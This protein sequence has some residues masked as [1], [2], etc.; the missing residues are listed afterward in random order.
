MRSFCFEFMMSQKD[1][2]IVLERDVTELRVGKG[3]HNE[4]GGCW[5][6]IYM[7]PS[8]L[9][10]RTHVLASTILPVTLLRAARH[11]C[12]PWTCSRRQRLL[13]PFSRCLVAQW[14]SRSWYV[15]TRQTCSFSFFPFFLGDSVKWWYTLSATCRR[16]SSSVECSPAQQLHSPVAFQPYQASML[17]VALI[18]RGVSVWNVLAGTCSPTMTER[19]SASCVRKLALCSG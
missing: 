5:K 17:I 3:F 6:N 1:R 9:V 11:S 18:V 10:P 7:W 19:T 4:L 8:V 2:R 12:W 13:R 16:I 15:R 14:R